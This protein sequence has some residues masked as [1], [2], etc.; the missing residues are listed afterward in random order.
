MKQLNKYFSEKDFANILNFASLDKFPKICD[1]CGEIFEANLYN[2]SFK[3]K[4]NI[5]CPSCYSVYYVAYN[6]LN[7]FYYLEFAE[8]PADFILPKEEYGRIYFG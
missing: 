5:K 4:L 1:Y 6:D 2:C 3:R 8:P 7:D